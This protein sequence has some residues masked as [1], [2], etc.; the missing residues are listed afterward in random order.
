MTSPAAW[1][2][3]PCLKVLRH[4]DLDG[5]LATVV[6][7]YGGVNLGVGGSPRTAS[8]TLGQVRHAAPD[9]RG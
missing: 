3:G 4:Q 2:G 7:Y 6:R 9:Q 1:P 8:R 5:V